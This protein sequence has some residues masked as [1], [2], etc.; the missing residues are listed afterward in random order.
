MFDW[1]FDILWLEI[2][3]VLIGSF[4]CVGWKFHICWLEVWYSWLEIWCQNSW[5]FD[6]FFMFNKLID[7]G[8]RPGFWNIIIQLETG[9]FRFGRKGW[10]WDYMGPPNEGKDYK[11]Y[12]SGIFPA[13]WVIIYYRSHPLQEPEKSIDNLRQEKKNGRILEPWNT[14]CLMTGSWPMAVGKFQ[15]KTVG[16]S[17]KALS[18]SM[19]YWLFNDGILI[20]VYEIIPT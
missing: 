1:K 5:K 19:N 12:I 13:N 8:S 7:Q 11:W 9:F 4:I 16:K 14:D 3:Y 20:T 10:A 18:H 6:V 15:Q 2:S 17:P